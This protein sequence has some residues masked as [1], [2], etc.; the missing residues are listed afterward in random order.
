M[1]TVD[2]TT[3]SATGVKVAPGEEIVARAGRY[4]RNT[5]Y[6]MTVVLLGMAGWFAYDGFITYPRDN[7]QHRRYV[8]DPVNNKDA[9]VHTETDIR[10]QKVLAGILPAVA[11]GL[12]GWTLYRSRGA[13]RLKDDVLSV[14]GHPD[15]PLEAIT[16]IDKSKWDRKGIAYLDYEL[17]GGAGAGA[18]T[19]GTLK[20]DDFI[21]ERPPTDRIMEAIE[22]K[23]LPAASA[24]GSEGVEAQ[25]GEGESTTDG[26]GHD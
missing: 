22:A 16:R 26:R 18:G 15:V 4:Y 8:A 5:R 11:A 23:L 9:P 3:T 7:E 19:T 20:L 24:P 6:V 17:P 13:Y 1:T 12:L 25:G 10:M 2:S 14:P 21:Y